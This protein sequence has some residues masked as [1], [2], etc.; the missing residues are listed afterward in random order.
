MQWKPRDAAAFT[1]A[2]LAKLP[3]G[4]I[5]SR[6]LGTPM[7]QV[8]RGLAGV[9]ERWAA[10]T[11]RFLITEAFPPTSGDLLPDW[12][13]V[14][15]LP[16]PCF[17]AAQT[18]E[19]RRRAVL[20]KLQRR[21]GAQSRAYFLG[22]AV[23]LGYHETIPSPHAVPAE[24]PFEAGRLNQVRIREFRPFMFGVSR[25]GDPTWRFAPPRMRF[26]W[27]VTVPGERLTWFRFGVSRLGQD[28]HLTIRR[29]EDLE[30]LLERYKP[31]HTNLI[32]NY[33]G[34]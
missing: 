30:C 7:V 3:L 25:F 24:V 27:I 8:C 4:E 22:L 11:A 16:E 13:R 10:R 28:P 33:T 12:E 32:F 5:W 21:P 29:A 19:E 20:E 31:A 18:L 34:V 1:H 26:V 14:L 9:V 6:A 15:G 23:R 2:L 17:T